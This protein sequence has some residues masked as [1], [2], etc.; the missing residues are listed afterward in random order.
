[1]NQPTLA[2]KMLLDKMS[3]LY[4]AKYWTDNQAIG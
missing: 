2:E 3:F 1:M 4:V